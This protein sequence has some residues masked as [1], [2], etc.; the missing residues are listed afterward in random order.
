MSCCCQAKTAQ[1]ASWNSKVDV[2]FWTL[3]KKH[4]SENHR[5]D[6]F[7]FCALVLVSHF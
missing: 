5:Y 6:G 1:G 2:V 3:F 4:I 7:A